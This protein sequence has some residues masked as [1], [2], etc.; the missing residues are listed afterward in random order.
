MKISKATEKELEIVSILANKMWK[1]SSVQD[2]ENEFKN[3]L[4][5]YDNAV[6]IAEQ[7]G[8]PIGFAH[9]SLRKDYVEGTE[10]RPVG[11]LEGVFVD[12]EYRRKGFAK[13]LVY[14]CEEWA[15]QKG[16]REF[17]SDCEL[18][19]KESICFHEHAGFSE[20][21]RIICYVK[22]I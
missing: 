2:L 3:V 8:N 10:S 19:N 13:E 20:T 7:N 22:K 4:V 15:S 14:A 16:C 5:S 11:Y 17:A 6:Y 1:E 21:N 9:C 12:V 18:E